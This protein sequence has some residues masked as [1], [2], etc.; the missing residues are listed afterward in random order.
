M[1]ENIDHTLLTVTQTLELLHISKPTLY[2][3]IVRGELIPQRAIQ[4]GKQ[5]R[6]F[7]CQTD[8]E[9]LKTNRELPPTK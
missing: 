5:C 6:K 7:F 1:C 3:I 4:R 9:T 2:K 8:V